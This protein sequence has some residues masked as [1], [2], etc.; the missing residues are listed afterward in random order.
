MLADQLRREARLVSY[1]FPPSVIY[2]RVSEK[3]FHNYVVWAA[4]AV[5]AAAIFFAGFHFGA[6]RGDSTALKT[7]TLVVVHTDTITRYLPPQI[8]SRVTHDTIRV[9]VREVVRDTIVLPREQVVYED[10]AYR[11]VVSGV[12]PRL[13]SIWVYRPTKVVT[14]TTTARE[15]APRWSFGVQGGVG[16]VAPV[17]GSPSV[18]GYLGVGLSYRFGK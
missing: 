18:G 17:G 7:D 1:E 9:C 8:E 3:F 14:I 11:A 6:K 2:E 12:R 16:L 15:A 13:D 10:T 5:I 4:A